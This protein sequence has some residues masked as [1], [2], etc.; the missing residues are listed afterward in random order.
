M[1]VLILGSG[2]IGVTSAWYLAKSGHDVTVIDKESNIVKGTAFANAGQISANYFA[3]WLAPGIPIKAIEW[4]IHALAPLKSNS[5]A[6]DTETL[7]WMTKMAA[8]CNTTDYPINKSRMMKIADYSRHC[9]VDLAN[10][11][12]IQQAQKAKGTLQ[13]FRSEHQLN[14]ATKELKT[15]TKCGVDLQLLSTEECLAYEP[16]LR[17]SHQ[18]ISG[19]I[20]L[21]NDES[22]DCQL[23]IAHLA[24]ECNKLGVKFV[25]DT[26]IEK[27]NKKANSITHV[28]TD[29]G[30]FTADA[31]VMA[32]GSY[33]TQMLAN[34]GIK[35]PVYPAKGYS[36]LMPIQDQDVAPQTTIMDETYKIAVSRSVSGMAEITDHDVASLD[37]RRE[38]ITFA[39]ND[40]F[41]HA[42]ELNKAVFSSGLRAMT[43][44]GTPIL[45]KTNIDNLYL[46]IGH[47]TLGWPVSLGSAKVVSDIINE[48]TLAVDETDFSIERYDFS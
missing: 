21:P 33:S 24:K 31:Y 29:K 5:K 1:K 28:A 3:P 47:G 12:N 7:V 18:K 6:L 30:L 26:C 2:V 40:L 43:P 48:N 36:L 19:G 34:I 15:L 46:N 20:L 42:T 10:E 23:Y 38:E 17:Q 4:L 8:N 44:D 41:P 16:A 45:G 27:L 25:M 39:I 37:K 11:I 32:L 35:V 14:E 22:G 9:L 13:I